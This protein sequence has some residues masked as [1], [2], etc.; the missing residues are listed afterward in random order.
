MSGRP[1]TTDQRQLIETLRKQQNI[2]AD[3]WEQ[4]C[5]RLWE[6]PYDA[7]DIRQASAMITSLKSEKAELK[8]EIQQIAG[9]R[10]LL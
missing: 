8:R 4:L 1:M 6:L 10:S 3:V 7:L 9:Q 5:Q 2:S